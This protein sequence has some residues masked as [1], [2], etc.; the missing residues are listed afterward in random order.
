[1]I[2]D[3]S[4]CVTILTVTE[5]VLLIFFQKQTSGKVAVFLYALIAYRCENI[6]FNSR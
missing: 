2:V 3:D 6:G 4:V 1:M 5:F